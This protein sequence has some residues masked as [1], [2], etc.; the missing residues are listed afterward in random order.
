MTLVAA[1]RKACHDSI[2]QRTIGE[3]WHTAYAQLAN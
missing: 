3:V 2:N 1:S